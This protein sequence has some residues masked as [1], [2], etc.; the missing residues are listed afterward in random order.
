MWDV[1]DDDRTSGIYRC[2]WAGSTN[3]KS[4]HYAGTSSATGVACYKD[5]G[6]NTRVGCTRQ[7]IK[8]DLAGTYQLRLSPR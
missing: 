5:S 8:G 7:G 3:V 2:S 6:H 1:A 4:V